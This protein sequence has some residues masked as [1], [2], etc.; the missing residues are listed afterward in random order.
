[1]KTLLLAIAFL[2]LTAFSR[3]T[4]ATDAGY[5]LESLAGTSWVVTET[6]QYPMT[7]DSEWVVT[8]TD[9]FSHQFHFLPDRPMVK[10][11]ELASTY[12]I[13][14]APERPYIYTGEFLKIE[15]PDP[16]VYIVAKIVEANQNRMEWSYTESGKAVIGIRFRRI[17]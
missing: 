7:E 1:M 16:E 4:P 11:I 2:S 13:L 3:K 8:E 9:G 12:N 5:R 15:F 6:N 10:Y 14:T 17:R